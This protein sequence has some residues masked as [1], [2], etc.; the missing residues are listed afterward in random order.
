MAL[1]NRAVNKLTVLPW[2]GGLDPSFSALVRKGDL[3]AFSQYVTSSAKEFLVLM[4]S[5]ERWEE[6]HQS[7]GSMRLYPPFNGGPRA[8]LGH[9]FAMIIVSHTIA[10]LLKTFPNL[11]LL[12]DVDTKEKVGAERQR[13]TLVL[14]PPDEGRVDI[15]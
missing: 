14:S 5:S 13:R 3:V 12:A 15:G 8:C 4:R 7:E 1:N 6:P 10:R 2:G 9:D 11:A